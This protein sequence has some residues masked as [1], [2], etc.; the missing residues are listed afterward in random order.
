MI[1]EKDQTAPLPAANE[2]SFPSLVIGLGD[3]GI[4]ETSVIRALREHDALA[5]VVGTLLRE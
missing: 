3:L 4:S 2:S 5:D 1:T